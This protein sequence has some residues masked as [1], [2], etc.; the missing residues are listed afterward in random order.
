MFG[1]QRID[2]D[3]SRDVENLY[4]WSQKATKGQGEAIVFRLANKSTNIP[5]EFLFLIFGNS[6]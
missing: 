5:T 4:I 2:F 1:F 3:Y 6:L